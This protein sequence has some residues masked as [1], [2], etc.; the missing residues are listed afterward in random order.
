MFKQSAAVLQHKLQLVTILIFVIA[1]LIVPAQ[2]AKAASLQDIGFPFPD[3]QTWYVYQGYNG[4]THHAN[5]TIEQTYAFDLVKNNWDNGAT[6]GG[7]QVIAAASGT[8][9]TWCDPTDSAHGCEVYIYLADG[10]VIY[11]SHL[12]NLPTTVGG[13]KWV[14]KGDP[15][16]LVTNTYPGG[17][18][19]LHFHVGI[20][21]RSLPLNF[22]VW[23]YPTPGPIMSGGP[24][25]SNGEWKGTKITTGGANQP[26]RVPRQLS[27]TDR[28]INNHLSVTFGWQDTGDPDN[29]PNA[30][31]DY[32]A[33]LWKSDNSWRTST[34]WQIATAWTVDLSAAGDGIYY[35]HVQSGDGEK[36][37]GWSSTWSFTIDTVAPIGM[38]T[39]NYGWGVTER[40]NILLGIN[41]SDSGSGV[42]DMRLSNDGDTW[43]SWQPLR[44]SVSWM[45]NGRHGD[46]ARVYLQCRDAAGNV[47]VV[48]SSSI[49][50]NFYPS[51]PTSARYRIVKD[52][53]AANGGQR[54]SAHYRINQTMGQTLA[55]G[56][57]ASGGRY[58]VTLGYWVPL[59]PITQPEKV[60]LP[61][62]LS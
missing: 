54:Q 2:S 58:R 30:Y 29:T 41:A 34:G 38:V 24:A 14:N 7:A 9:T 55:S 26:P 52:V 32:Y 17:V 16:G 61:M 15:I 48:S 42:H 12:M 1:V 20:K 35:W 56:A 47:S 19:H 27:P 57:F 13:G 5:Q 22:G 59:A 51:L 53:V 36:G 6:T 44:G 33:E 21:A 3:G 4:V 25:G 18:N 43:S 40:L 39:T 31:R 10:N 45:L 50:L 8:T 49:T 37:S 62:T 23:H 28:T 60:Y 46:M 11:N